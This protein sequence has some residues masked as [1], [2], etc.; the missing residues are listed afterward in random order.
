[1]N[2]A[3][4]RQRTCF[5]CGG[6]GTVCYGD[7]EEACYGCDGRGWV[8]DDSTDPRNDAVVTYTLPASWCPLCGLVTAA[9]GCTDPFHLPDKEK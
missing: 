3:N 2:D 9:F 5:A 4:E 1:M 8:D 7:A 6:M